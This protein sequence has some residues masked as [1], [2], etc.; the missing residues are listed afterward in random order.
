[1]EFS[2]NLVKS[3]M[4]LSATFCSVGSWAESFQ[5]RN[6]DDAMMSGQDG[7]A[8]MSMEDFK[9]LLG[10][11]SRDTSGNR[12]NQ[13]DDSG[14]FLPSLK[15]NSE[16]KEVL[17]KLVLRYEQNKEKLYK[18]N[19][20]ASH[21]AKK[22]LAEK[23][24]HIQLQRL[25]SSGRQDEKLGKALYMNLIKEANINA[26]NNQKIEA[27]ENDNKVYF[28]FNQIRGQKI[29][30]KISVGSKVVWSYQASGRML[31]QNQ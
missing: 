18:Q 21:K 15:L 2:K 30:S 10:F 26:Q 16:E 31:A 12:L 20:S 27:F 23:R 17:L 7:R 22:E 11:D 13:D 3:M 25:S 4:L 1:M 19:T 14:A 29:V 24:R 5:E 6:S 9:T 8:E 28:S